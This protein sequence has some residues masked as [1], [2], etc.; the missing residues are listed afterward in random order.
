MTMSMRQLVNQIFTT[1][2]LSQ[3]QEMLIEGA[4]LQQG[5]RAD[6]WAALEKL[7]DGMTVG[8]IQHW[9]AKS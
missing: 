1:R 7:M 8:S 3:E 4:I 2:Y 9:S 5:L 6:E